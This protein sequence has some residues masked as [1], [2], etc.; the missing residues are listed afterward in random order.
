MEIRDSEMTCTPKVRQKTFGVHVN[1]D[2]RIFYFYRFA[3]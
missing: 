2:S 3:K 1:L